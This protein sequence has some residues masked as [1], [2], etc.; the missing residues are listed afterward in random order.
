MKEVR[1]EWTNGLGKAAEVW[2]D[3][4]LLNVCDNIST[5]RQ[6]CPPGLLENVRFSYVTDLNASWADSVRANPG[7]RKRLERVRG[8]SYL[9]GGQVVSVMPVVIDFGLLQMPD[10][11]WSTDE[12]LIGRHVEVHIDRLELRAG[13]EPEWPAERR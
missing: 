2:V 5:A 12:S 1:M 10:P 7:A 6:R 3:G 11:R 8:W 13:R 4:T 9:G